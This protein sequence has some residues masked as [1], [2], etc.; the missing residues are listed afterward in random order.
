MDKRLSYRNEDD[1]CYGATGMAIGILVFN[2][3]DYL[4]SISLDE[5]P[6]AMVEMQDMFYFNGNP[7]LSAK[8][9]W[10]RIKGS[11]DLSV[12]MLIGNLMCR[13][14]VHDN[15]PVAE[16]HRKAIREMVAEEGKESCGLD[17]DEI[18]RVFDKEYS[19]LLRVFNHQGVQGVAHDFADTLK[20]RRRL[21]RL[22]VLE[23]LRALSMF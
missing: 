3:E 14:I 19:I 21:S 4:S 20:R 8:S 12:A 7:V 22:E 15:K 6:S 13:S 1:K 17:D 5:A 9:V 23:Q 16:E 11:Y 10:T 2:G 18:S